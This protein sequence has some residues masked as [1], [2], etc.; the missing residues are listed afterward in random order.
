MTARD[1]L[2]R[3]LFI[4]DNF[5]QPREAS[6]ADWEYFHAEGRFQ[7]RVEHYEVMANAVLAAGYRK[8]VLDDAVVE[9]AA[10]A[11]WVQVGEKAEDWVYYPPEDERKVWLT[12]HA[13]VALATVL[14]KAGQ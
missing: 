3:E 7:G 13:K 2:A 4:G 12:N 9:R 5:N 1:D 14:H 8:L 10:K 11:L 6:I